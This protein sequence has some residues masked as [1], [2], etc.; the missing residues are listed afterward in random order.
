M[1]HPYIARAESEREFNWSA[2]VDQEPD[3]GLGNGGL[4]LPPASSIRWRR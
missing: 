3:A 2:V 1:L 4:G